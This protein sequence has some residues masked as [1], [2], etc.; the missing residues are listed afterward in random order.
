MNVID[1]PK[2][3]LDQVNY[4][5]LVP[6]WTDHL[7]RTP[8]LYHSI[9]PLVLS[10]EIDLQVPSQ[11][12]DQLVEKDPQTIVNDHLVETAPT[13]GR[14]PTVAIDHSQITIDLQHL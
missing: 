6:I 1:L 12:N 3:D 5:N 4:V 7:V 10:K 13:T 11:E 2:K 9:D 8:E 14:D